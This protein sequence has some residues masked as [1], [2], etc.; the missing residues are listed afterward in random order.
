[1]VDKKQI[2]D[3]L[4]QE[5]ELLKLS[6]CPHFNFQTV[7]DKINSLPDEIVIDGQLWTLMESKGEITGIAP[8][9]EL[10]LDLID[11]VNWDKIWK[12]ID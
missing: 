2:R 9:T 3:K 12:K 7:Q 4:I 10:N 11:D 8:F 6:K 5:S 1:M